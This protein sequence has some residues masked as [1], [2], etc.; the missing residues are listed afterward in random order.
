MASFGK[1]ARR[2]FL[3]GAVAL[4]GGVAFGVW[5]VRK[6]VENPLG[7]E[8]GATLNPYVLINADGLTIIAPRAEMGQGIHTTL[9]ALVAEELDADF[10]AI[11]VLHGPP[12]AAYYNAA[13][14][15][16]VI[17]TPDYAQKDWQRWVAGAIGE[18]SKLLGLQ[19]TGGSTSTVDAYE[20][21]RAAGASAREAL[22]AAASARLG[23]PVA[24][25][26][27]E[28]GAVIAPDGTTLDYRALAAAA[29]AL[30][31]PQVALREPKDWKLLGQPLP[32]VD[33]RA[34]ITG[35]AQY[36]T[37]IALPGLR[38]A[39]VRCNPHLGGGMR[40]FDARP[41]LAM[42]GVEQ[43]VDLGNG[44]GV[45]ARN[46]WAAMQGAQAVA[47]DWG[48]SALPA[49]MD[50]MLGRIAAAFDDK[51]NSS[52]RDQGSMATLPA[53]ALAVEY[54]VPFL[55]HATMEPMGATAWLQDGKLTLWVGHQAPLEAVKVAARLTGLREQDVTL[56]TTLLGGG[57]GRRTEMDN[58]AQAVKLAMA[59][60]GTPIRLTWSRE[61]DMTHDFYRPAAM[62]RARGAVENGRISHFDLHVAAPSVTRAAIGRLTGRAMG[63]ADKGH[64][65]G[66][67][68]Q[69][70][71]IPNYRTLGYLADLDVPI[72]FWRSV[73][74]SF[75]G[76]FHESLMDE[77]AHAAG[78]DPLQ[79]RLDHLR[80]ESAVAAGVLDAV[81]ELS[82]WDSPKPP[83]IG[84]GVAFCWSFGT[85]TA[86]VM[87]VAESRAGIVMTRAYVAADP[88]RVLDPRIVAAQLE[89]GLIYGLS[90]AVSEAITFV[91]GAVEQG[92]FPDYD[93]LRMA[94]APRIT[95]VL[96]QDNPHMGGVG[97]VATP[98]AAPALA[99]AIF[100]LTGER[101]RA[102]PLD[103]T[104]RFAV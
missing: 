79:F 34:K 100:D 102:L 96:R 65:E 25:L 41:A 67:F 36:S 64:M 4:T 11:T 61:E 62:A 55:A 81:R 29:A 21:M 9:A 26:R 49:D 53:G 47:V 71:A 35:R 48:P 18:A 86:V 98:P 94:S 51:P 28:N 83:G 80:P 19:V 82:G 75:N 73:G 40:S 89:S 92:N 27:T 84:R 99:N 3:V 1:I 14:A 91:D 95:T 90:A 103:R 72:G 59:V 68:N 12:A 76:F 74:N 93:A 54:A 56:H 58:V 85:P 30:P 101:L 5:Q 16:G 60:P 88:G 23:V 37:D 38:F 13:L 57:F 104:L 32:R 22:K 20:R 70:Y 63:G 78:A 17:P 42:D 15:H 44:V 52:F 43:V 87:E 39:N 69:P 8:D 24:Q 77:L 50:A 7:P 97:E 6:P 66:A 45:I 46:T 2:T 33:M 31:V 10:S